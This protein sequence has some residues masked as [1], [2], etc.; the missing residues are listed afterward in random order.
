MNRSERATAL[1]AS[2]GD[3]RIAL[4]PRTGIN[5]YLV[6]PRPSA[7]MAY[8]SSTA[9]DISPAAFAEVQRRM[10][11][12]A[13]DGVLSAEAYRAALDAVRL[14][15]KRAMNL[16]ASTEIVFHEPVLP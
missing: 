10:D 1:M 9:N 3:R 12:V 16:P 5:Q 14:R 13:P 7:I 6:A 11:R 15:I 4:D 8:S 2:G